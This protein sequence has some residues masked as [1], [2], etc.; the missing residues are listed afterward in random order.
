[1]M[2]NDVTGPASEL[3]GEMTSQ[4]QPVAAGIPVTSG[5]TGKRQRRFFRTKFIVD[6]GV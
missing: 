1:M 5:F 3:P 6:K 2:L 4:G